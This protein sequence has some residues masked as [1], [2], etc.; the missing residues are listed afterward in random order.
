MSFSTLLPTSRVV[1]LPTRTLIFEV[2]RIDGVPSPTPVTVHPLVH[3]ALL[4]LQ[5]TPV[6]RAVFASAL[7]TRMPCDPATVKKI[8]RPRP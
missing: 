6:K 8:C 1:H 4:D 5:L 2:V 7:N 3:N